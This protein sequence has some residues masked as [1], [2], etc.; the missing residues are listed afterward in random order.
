M[1]GAVLGTVAPVAGQSAVTQPLA[2]L[3]IER[4]RQILIKSSY[5]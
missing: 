2:V 5:K 4:E 1:P 3:P